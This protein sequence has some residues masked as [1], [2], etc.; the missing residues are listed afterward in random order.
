V[1]HDQK[2]LA[3]SLKS[4]Y[5]YGKIHFFLTLGTLFV[6]RVMAATSFSASSTSAPHRTE[7]RP[8]NEAMIL[9]GILHRHNHSFE[10]EKIARK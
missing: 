7:I 3:D 9:N 5:C 6:A 2:Q 8:A 10:E 4:W 1:I